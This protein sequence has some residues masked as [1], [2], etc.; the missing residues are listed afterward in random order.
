VILIIFINNVQSKVNMYLTCKN[1]LSVEIN[2]NHC[3]ILS[4]ILIEILTLTIIENEIY[5][6]PLIKSSNF[7][8]KNN[9]VYDPITKTKPLFQYHFG[10]MNFNFD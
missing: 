6:L 9:K 4:K 8:L 10:F 2:T 1:S 5:C 3:W 7:Y